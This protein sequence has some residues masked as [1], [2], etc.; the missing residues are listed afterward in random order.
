MLPSVLLRPWLR[1]G[2]MLALT[3]WTKRVMAVPTKASSVALLHHH[4]MREEAYVDGRWVAARSGRTFRVF[5][6]AD[7]RELGSVPDMD[8]EDAREAVASARRA[9][10]TWQT[11]TAKERSGRLRRW[12]ELM[13]QNQEELAKVL[14]AEQ[15]KPLKDAKG[16]IAYGASFLEWFSEE[17]RRIGGEVVQSPSPTKEMLFVRQPIGVVGL[18][19]PW[20][21]PNAMLARKA[22]AALA[23]G[24]TCVVKPAEDTPYS[25]LA[26]AQLAHEASIPPG[27]FNVVTSSRKNTPKVGRLLCEH[28]DVAGISFTGSTAVGKI[29]YQQCA[30]TV[31]RLSLELGGNAPFIVFDSADLDAAVEGTVASKFRCSGQTCVSANRILVQAGVFDAFVDRLARRMAETLVVGDGFDPRTTQGPLANAQ[32]AEKVDRLVQDAVSR[33][34]TVVAGGGRHPMG[35]LFYQP[36]LLTDIDPSMLVFNEEIFGPVAS[37]IKFRTEDEAVG[38][39]NSSNKGLAGYFFSRDIAQIWRVAKRLEMGMVGVNEGLISTA[40]AAFGGIK[41]SGIGREGSR[42]GIDE[43][44]Y[45]KYICFGGL[46]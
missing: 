18:I 15:G 27:V 34:A 24:C 11:T 29:L 40:E 43:Y 17:A 13:I 3:K 14:T 4:W 35:D 26:M 44:T 30:S 33:G 32:Q 23:S 41:E 42:H 36:T 45:I 19:T 22:A 31:K 21:F 5:N 6:P 16:E 7:G 46:Q 37:I 39:A 9:F 20:N 28:P 8:E 1:L 38:I 10:R 2:E 25:A 12:F